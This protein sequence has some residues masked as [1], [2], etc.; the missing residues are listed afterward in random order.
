LTSYRVIS[1]YI[2]M[3]LIV[4]LEEFRLERK[5][6]QE[7]LAEMLGVH[8]I[9]VNRWFKGHQKPSKMQEWHIKKLLKEE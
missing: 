3:E 7:K 1:Y 5:I 4:K 8:F 9:T 2:I 6:S